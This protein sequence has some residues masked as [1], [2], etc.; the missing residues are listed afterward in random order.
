MFCN[1]LGALCVDRRIRIAYASHRRFPSK[2]NQLVR[3]I[4]RDLEANDTVVG[5]AVCWLW[6]L[7]CI[8]PCFCGFGLPWRKLTDSERELSILTH[9]TDILT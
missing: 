7:W 2:P 9:C 6:V 4:Q 3:T 8:Q 5:H 1:L